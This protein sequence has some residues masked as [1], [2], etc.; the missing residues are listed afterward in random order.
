MASVESNGQQGTVHLWNALSGLER[1]AFPKEKGLLSWQNERLSGD[2]AFSPHGK[3][4]AA[5]G[6]DSSVPNKENQH[7]FLWDLATGRKLQK[8]EKAH[9]DDKP[10]GLVFSPDGKFLAC[11]LRAQAKGH[12]EVFLWELASGKRLSRRF[13]GWSP[14]FSPDGTLLATH[15]N[16]GSDFDHRKDVIY[17]W[18]VA[19]GKKLGRIME[20][21]C[22]SQS[23]FSPNGQALLASVYNVK[24]EKEM[25]LMLYPL[26]RGKQSGVR[27]GKARP[28]R[29]LRC[30]RRGKFR[31]KVRCCS[32]QCS[33]FWL[34]GIKIGAFALSSD[35]KMLAAV[36][37]NGRT[38]YLWETATGK[39]RCRFRGHIDGIQSL[40]FSPDGRRLASG[41]SDT[42]VLIWDVTGRLDE[43]GRLRPV[44][45][46]AKQ[47]EERWADLKGM[48]A[49]SA[50]QAIWTLVAAG[51]PT[52][53]FLAKQLRPV[54]VGVTAKALD[55]LIADL[56][57]NGFVVRQKAR[58]QLEAL[59]ELAEPG[60]RQA[61][62]KQ[63]SLELRR[64][65]DHLL[66]LIEE[67][68]ARPPG[69]MLRML[70]AIEVLEHL[71][72]PKARQLLEILSSGAPGIRQTEETKASLT[73]LARRTVQP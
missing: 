66:A 58:R 2:V 8:L 73:R 4:A 39:E 3:I 70:R 6:L 33:F 17:L 65:L 61:L 36:D 11:T 50:N 20:E 71:G 1:L 40:D 63:P 56:E 54:P 72:T 22:F 7:I 23:V 15:Y 24:N 53:A 49:A 19:T 37:H 44:R 32:C 34:R 28:M 57:N 48:D 26:Y 51:Q 68:R 64:S 46:S 60:L 42:T 12:D 43:Q 41:S 47:M 5:I 21:F 27:F 18:E 30:L 13:R 69:E 16:E 52:I 25:K 9:E 14:T 31:E 55:L 67:Q 29:S 35:G 45:L 10:D 62:E 59:G 38:V